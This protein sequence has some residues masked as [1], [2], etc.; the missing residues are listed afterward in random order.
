M[1]SS[2][3]HV[4]GNLAKPGGLSNRLMLVWDPINPMWEVPVQD[5][6]PSTYQIYSYIWNNKNWVNPTHQAN[7]KKLSWNRQERP[8]NCLT[9]NLS[10]GAATI[11]GREPKTWN[12]FLRSKEFEPY[13]SPTLRPAPERQ[14]PKHLTLKTNGLASPVVNW[15]TVFRAQ[16]HPPQDLPQRQPVGRCPD[17]MWK[18]LHGI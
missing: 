2:R 14:P 9:I 10:P 18:R 8:R 12:P 1:L 6:M 13:I 7:E 4:P 11:T 5:D 16:T 3:P 15:E 17:F